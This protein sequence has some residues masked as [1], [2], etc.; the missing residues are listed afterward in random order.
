[1]VCSFFASSSPV[2]ASA[3]SICSGCCSWCCSS[4]AWACLHSLEQL[5][6]GQLAALGLIEQLLDLG[7]VVVELLDVVLLGGGA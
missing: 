5:L 2:S 4:S 6:L 1:L 7:G 3:L